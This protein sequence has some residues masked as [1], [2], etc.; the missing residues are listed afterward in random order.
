MIPCY[1]TH[2]S[3]PGDIILNSLVLCLHAGQRINKSIQE[4]HK[5]WV[6]AAEAYSY[7]AQF[8]L[9]QGAKNG[10][11]FASSTK[12]RLGENVVLRLMECLTSPFNFN[13]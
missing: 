3:K 10:K 13:F 12:W 2:G 8:R 7:V 11:Q 4:E 1:G 9:Y 5:I 6:L